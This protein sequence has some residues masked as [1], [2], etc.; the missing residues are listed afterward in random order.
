MTPAEYRAKAE[1][2]LEQAQAAEPKGNPQL[3]SL[4][5]RY[6]RLADLAEKNASN[7]MV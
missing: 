2:L 4:A 1:L 7:D 6:L 5:L 3:V